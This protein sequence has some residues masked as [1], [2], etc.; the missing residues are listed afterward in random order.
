[1]ALL[2]ECVYIRRVVRFQKLKI[3]SASLSLPDPNI[4]R[5]GNLQHQVCLQVAMPPAMIAMY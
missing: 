2:E 5:S 3:G 1:M 4:E